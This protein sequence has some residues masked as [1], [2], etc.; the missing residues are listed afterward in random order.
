V[1]P[2]SITGPLILVT[3][4]VLFLLNNVRPD[5]LSFSMI[6]D[7]WP[8]LLI[9]AGAI[10]LI[11]VLFHAARGTT[12]APRPLAGAG[13]FWIVVVCVIAGVLSGNHDFR[14]ARFDRPGISVFGSD[15]EYDVNASASPQGVT[16]IIFDN[17]RG[18]ISVKGEDSG[19]VKVTGRKTVRA[20]HRGDA[21]RANERTQVRIERNGDLLLVRA[22]EFNGARMIQ[23]TT[24]LDITLPRGIS[25]ESRGR[26]GDLT[27]DDIDGTVDVSSAR[28]DVRL[29]HIARDVKI[30]SSRS[31][32]IRAVDLKGNLDLEGRGSDLQLENIAGAVTINGEYSGTIEFQAL[33]KP[34]R[35]QSSRTEFRVEAV[36]GSITLDLGNLKMTNVSG[37]V[38]FQT[39]TRDIQVSDVTNALDL[40]VDRGD[41]QV[42]ASKGPL[43]KMDV[44]SRNGDIALTLPDHAGFELNGST[45]QGEV[46]NEFGNSLETHTDGRAATI[47]GQTGNGPQ[48]RVTTDRGSVTVK[49]G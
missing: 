37:P 49:K 13:I 36:P 48:I 44:H 47:R 38:R 42:T 9:G 11:E 40:T 2:R 32:V 16:R 4:G 46:E 15:F 35:F 31:G 22:E 29:S 1:R 45:S 20:F 24:D 6:A 19:D 14:F 23:I 3:I 21:D 5:F 27:I 25:V 8:F 18:N 12:P 33:A 10:G 34:M 7:Y 41:I 17:I 39:R 28:G 30:A 43:P 26:T